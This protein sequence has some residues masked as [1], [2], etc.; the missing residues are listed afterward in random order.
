[1]IILLVDMFVVLIIT[2]KFMAYARFDFLK[3]VEHYDS[4]VIV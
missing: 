3:F 1:M 2:S 4:Y